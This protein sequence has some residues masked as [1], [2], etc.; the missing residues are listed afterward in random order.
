MKIVIYILL[1]F[2]CSV[3]VAQGDDFF[4]V[5]EQNKAAERDAARVQADYARQQDDIKQAA[6][7]ADQK[8]TALQ[9]QRAMQER[10]AANRVA[11]INAKVAQDKEDA[12]ARAE[13]EERL[14]DK[15]R[16][17]AQEDEERTYQIRASELKLQEAQA[18]ADQRTADADLKKAITAAKLKRVNEEVD[19]QHKRE[20]SN[21]DVIQS[22][23]D[24]TRNVSSGAGEMLSGLGSK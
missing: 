15:A 9:E 1:L 19:I 8:R 14:K 24:A 7:R 4:K 11:A 13:N 6:I 5:E 22:E 10:A 16:A 18:E 20:S 12:R 21:I 23:A 3:Y 2:S 17:Q